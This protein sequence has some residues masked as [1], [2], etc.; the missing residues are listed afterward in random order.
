MIK[1][2]LVLFQFIIVMFVTICVVSIYTQVNYMVSKDLGYDKENLIRVNFDTSTGKAKEIKNELLQNPDIIN[3]TQSGPFI[4][5]TMETSGWNWKGNSQDKLSVFKLEVGSDF[6]KTMNIDIIKGGSFSD[7]SESCLTEVMINQAAYKVMGIE[8]CIGMIIKLKK[9]EY[10][11]VG[12][13][14]DFHFSHL[15]FKIK[16]LL[17]VYD[18]NNSTI[19]R[20][21]GDSKHALKYIE[22][23]YNKYNTSSNPFSYNFISDNITALYGDER[24]MKNSTSGFL[25]VLFLLSIMAMMG[26]MSSHISNKNKEIGLRKVFGAHG[27]NIIAFLLL[28]VIKIVVIAYIIA[29]PTAIVVI[30]KWLAGFAN[31][32]EINITAYVLIGMF[33]ILF[34]SLVL[35]YQSYKASKF[36][37]IKIL[38]ETS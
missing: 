4:N 32:A 19:I 25:L 33:F 3:V 28:D 5:L 22:S 29:V 10:K 26:M 36:S 8:D 14:K 27:A 13:I 7:N 24:Q 16:P 6:T 11:V 35:L 21:N 23:V 34:T 17:I 12:V 18:E 31:Q 20:L 9:K 2:G 38:R 15:K 30:K 37:P 1:K